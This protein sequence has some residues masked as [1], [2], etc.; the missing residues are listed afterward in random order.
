MLELFRMVEVGTPVTIV[1]GDGSGGVFT[2]L[3]RRHAA[4]GGSGS[5]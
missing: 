3:V 5:R 1:G 4:R 2:D